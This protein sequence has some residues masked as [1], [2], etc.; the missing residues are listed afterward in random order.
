MPLPHQ[1][2]SSATKLNE[3]EKV[4]INGKTEMHHKTDHKLDSTKPT[5]LFKYFKS[6]IRDGSDSKSSLYISCISNVYFMYFKGFTYSKIKTTGS[7]PFCFCVPPKTKSTQMITGL[8]LLKPTPPRRT[9]P[10]GWL[11]VVWTTF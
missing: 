5:I 2:L 1:L 3:L 10:P 8:R 4:H 7:Q 11:P 9:R 6:S